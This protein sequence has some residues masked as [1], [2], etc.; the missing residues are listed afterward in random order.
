MQPHWESL[1]PLY[2]WS[3]CWPNLKLCSVSLH[4]VFSRLITFTLQGTVPEH[5]VTQT[6]PNTF[7]CV[8]MLIIRHKLSVL[9][10]HRIVR[11]I[12]KWNCL[13]RTHV[14]WRRRDCIET[15]WVLVAQHRLISENDTVLPVLEQPITSVAQR[16]CQMQIVMCQDQISTQHANMN[17]NIYHTVKSTHRISQLCAYILTFNTQQR[18]IKQKLKRILKGSLIFVFSTF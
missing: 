4:F 8:K 7:F 15:L 3:G 9:M 17:H 2:S 6:V 5:S 16:N 14:A 11:V 10:F 13:N 12:L 18:G 1:Y